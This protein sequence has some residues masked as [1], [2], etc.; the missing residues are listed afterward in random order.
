[1]KAA[2][3]LCSAGVVVEASDV[4]GGFYC[5]HAFFAAK[6]AAP[7][8]LVGFVHVPPEHQPRAPL[9]TRHGHIREVIVA[10]LRATIRAEPK[11]AWR[12][13]LTGYAPWG[14][15]HHNPSGDFVSHATN[16]RAIL[17]ALGASRS[18]K[19]A[20]GVIHAAIHGV[21]DVDVVGDAIGGNGVDVGIAA[22]VLAVDDSAIDGGPRSIQAAIAAHTP[23]VVISLGVKRGAVGVFVECRATDIALRRHGAGFVRDP[24]RAE[25]TS[26]LRD[27]RLYRSVVSGWPTSTLVSSSASSSSS[28]FSAL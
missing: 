3:L 14:A 26:I 12:V 5:E 13:L 17:T 21:G 10:A 19:G 25:P 15:V 18:V 8:A 28:S 23:D 27:D 20:N 24:S 9:V 2:P 11:S 1:M 16:T 6:A 7:E 4:A 22:V